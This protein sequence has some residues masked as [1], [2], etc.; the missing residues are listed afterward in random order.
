MEIRKK[1]DAGYKVEMQVVTVELGG[2]TQGADYA[3]KMRIFMVRFPGSWEHACCEC[4]ASH[5][6]CD[7]CQRL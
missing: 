1:E 5:V 4:M 3:S 7:I 6:H 2:L